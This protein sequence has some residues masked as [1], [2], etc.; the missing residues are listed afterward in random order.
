MIIFLLILFILFS[1]AILI[2][3][4]YYV[5]RPIEELKEIK[6]IEKLQEQWEEDRIITRQKAEKYNKKPL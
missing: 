3:L 4:Y 2:T 1:G 6:K 5:V